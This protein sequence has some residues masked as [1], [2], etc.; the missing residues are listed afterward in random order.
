M[1]RTTERTLWIGGT[2]AGALALII[3]AVALTS[4]GAAAAAPAKAPV[5]GAPPATPMAAP[6]SAANQVYN[7]T[8]ADNGKTFNLKPGDQ[9]KIALPNTQG[10][11]SDWLY[12]SATPVGLQFNGRVNTAIG[13]QGG[14]NAMQELDTWTCVPPQGQSTGTA[15]SQLVIVAQPVNAQG[16][17]TGPVTVS[18]AITVNVSWP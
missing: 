1:E 17:P 10:S 2:A 7:L 13:G 15:S 18:F 3:G 14:S 9:L 5:P 12:A 6:P 11:G 16:Q 8:I 4:K